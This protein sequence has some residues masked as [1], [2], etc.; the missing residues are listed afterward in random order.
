M[1]LRSLS[2]ERSIGVEVSL[3]ILAYACV[4]VLIAAPL[5]MVFLG[6]FS[7]TMG[8]FEFSLEHFAA[9][10]RSANLEAIYNTIVVATFST[11]FAVMLGFPV[12]FL[13]VR[14][15]LPLSGVVEMISAFPLYLN[16]L[17][18]AIGWI[19][20]ASPNIGLLNRVVHSVLPGLTFDIY[21]P[22][23]MGFAMG[24]F[25]SPYVFLFCS[26]ALR[27]MDPELEEA[28]RITGASEAHTV[29]H[30]TLPLITPALISAI[31]LVFVLSASLFS[32][33][34]LIG[35]TV[36]YHVI[37]TMIYTLIAYPPPRYGEAAT[38]SAVLL[39]VTATFTLILRRK[40]DVKR[41]VTIGGKGYR[42]RKLDIGVWRY[43]VFAVCIAAQVLLLLLPMLMVLVTSFS[44]NATSF[45]F[46]LNNY[47]LI[48]YGWWS[49]FFWR[50]TRNSL[51]ISTVGATLAM[52]LS[53]VVSYITVRTNL[54]GR[55]LL[56][57]LS[58]SSIAVPGVVMAVG[59]IFFWLSVPVPMYGT[60][61]ILILA[62]IGKF[63]AYG[64]RSI[65]AS[66]VQ[67]SAEL[68]ECAKICGASLLR[69][70][71][72]VTIPLV[73]SGFYSGWVLLFVVSFREAA[74]VV[75]LYTYQTITL[76][77]LMIDMFNSTMFTVFSS[78]G[79]LQMAVIWLIV[80]VFRKAFGVQVRMMEA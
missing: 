22:L 42:P 69:T 12:A 61:W 17:A 58:T 18:G 11:I 5:C 23:G 55:G 54:R 30:V 4:L 27:A 67:I 57:H 7:K 37:S 33:P 78:I 3:Q 68:E 19:L 43:A 8:Q 71:R 75:L 44:E 6:A 15:N 65:S 66:L 45:V 73:K 79:V 80:I 62:G 50:A 41:Y 70:I 20:L 14:T 52:L 10:G 56:D 76:S 48:F 24:V 28:S 60:I 32:I 40:L 1:K 64:V 38:L 47:R 26:S 35:W 2:K 16:P 21:T 53:T 25:Y 59:M 46:T 39:L 31:L 72:D 36:K 49:E 77:V 63:L 29:L 9:L 74:M 51:F 13:S 34:L